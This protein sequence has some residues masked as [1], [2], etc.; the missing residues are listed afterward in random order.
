MSTVKHILKIS[1]ILLELF[2][3]L[4]GISNIVPLEGIYYLE[5]SK[6]IRKLNTNPLEL[7]QGQNAL[8][9]FHTNLTPVRFKRITKFLKFKVGRL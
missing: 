2:I 9:K 7:H 1:L 8:L 3:G 6:I 4:G 5:N